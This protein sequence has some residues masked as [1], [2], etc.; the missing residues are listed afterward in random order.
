MGLFSKLTGAPAPGPAAAI[1]AEP[2]AK[3][4]DFPPFIEALAGVERVRPLLEQA[5][6]EHKAA[7]EALADI[8]R[9]AAEK[10]VAGEANITVTIDQCRRR[11][12]SAGTALDLAFSAF[13]LARQREAEARAAFVATVEEAVID[14][15]IELRWGLYLAMDEAFND[16]SD[17]LMQDAGKR[18]ASPRFMRLAPCFPIVRRS[19]LNRWSGDQAW[20]ELEEKSKARRVDQDGG[21]SPEKRKLPFAPPKR[22]AVRIL[23]P[24]LCYDAN[25]PQRYGAGELAWFA[26]E[27]AD[28]LVKL[29]DAEYAA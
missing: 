18:G 14:R 15:I 23:K 24:V 16:T 29:G 6:A 19:L 28:K 2:L 25:Q 11:S 26:T 22:I 8:T 12:Q 17:S 5:E 13:H 7:T 4:E 1:D 3:L 27:Q 10:I 20:S 9:D 21:V